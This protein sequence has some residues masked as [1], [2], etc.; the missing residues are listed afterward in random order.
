LL[1]R[2]LV[3]VYPTAVNAQSILHVSSRELIQK[4][5][6]D[7]LRLH[8]FEVESTL[9]LSEAL[10]MARIRNFDLVLIDVE[11]PNR[12]A[13]AELLCDSIK[14]AKPKQLIAYLCNHRISFES[15]CPDEIIRAEFNPEFLVQSVKQIIA[16]E[17]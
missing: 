10:E 13:E 4:L 2:W 7:I 1:T 16:G 6:D 14:K 11:G 3:V 15:D 12:I 17:V 8:G 5:R 9:W